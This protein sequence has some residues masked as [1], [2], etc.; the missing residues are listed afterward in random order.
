MFPSAETSRDSEAMSSSR[1]EQ[2]A[3]RETCGSPTFRPAQYTGSSFHA[4]KIVTAAPGVS[5][6]CTNSPEA[7]RSL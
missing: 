5:S 2:S 4:G 3:A 6:T 1:S 7:R